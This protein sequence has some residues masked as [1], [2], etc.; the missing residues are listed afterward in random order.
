MK[1]FSLSLSGESQKFRIAAIVS[2]SMLMATQTAFAARR[3]HAAARG[4][5][6]AEEEGAVSASNS[7]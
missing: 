7:T 2:L 4:E 5:A 3:H 1:V 6:P